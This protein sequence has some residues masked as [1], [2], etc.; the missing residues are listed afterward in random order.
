[1]EVMFIASNAIQVLGKYIDCLDV[2]DNAKTNVTE[3]KQGV[4][5]WCR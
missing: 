3:G 4:Q 5:I 1:M 2:G